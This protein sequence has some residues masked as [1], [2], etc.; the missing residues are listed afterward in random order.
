MKYH[1]KGFT[2]CN[3][4]RG[5]ESYDKCS[6]QLAENGFWMCF[7]NWKQ[8]YNSRT[9]SEDNYFEGG[10]YN[11]EYVS[12]LMDTNASEEPPSSIFRKKIFSTDLQGVSLQKIIIERIHTFIIPF[13]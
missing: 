5:S 2:F 6:K 12:V 3:R 9:A 4:G 1:L 8:R 11:S 7:D 13:L 10:H